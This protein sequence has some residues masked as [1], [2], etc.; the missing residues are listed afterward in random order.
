MVELTHQATLRKKNNPSEGIPD[1]A[2]GSV[3]SSNMAPYPT[4]LGSA[5]ERWNYCL[6][7]AS[8]IDHNILLQ[9]KHSATK[10]NPRMI[11]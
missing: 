7:S 8:H 6:L 4:A 9:K 10:P 11:A 2:L 3:V 1:W 5:S